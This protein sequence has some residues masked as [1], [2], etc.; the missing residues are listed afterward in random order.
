M[1]ESKKLTKKDLTNAAFRTGILSGTF[2]YE[3]MMG[4]GFAA[5]I[6]PELKKIYGEDEEGLR[7]ALVD[8]SALYNTQVHAGSFINGLILAL[9]EAKTDREVINGIRNGLF[10]PFAGIGDA[11]IWYTVVPLAAAVCGSLAKSG[12]V[13]G[14][15]LYLAIFTALY[16][17]RV[18]IVNM[19]YNLGIE[20]IDL[21]KEKTAAISE[22]ASILGL[23]V[24]GGLISSYISITLKPSIQ[25]SE[26]ASVS[27][28]G[29]LFDVIFPNILGAVFT[30]V[31]YRLLK[32]KNVKPTTLIIATV[33]IAI[34]CSYLGI[35]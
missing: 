8:H 19:G 27:L 9:E 28:Q 31:I 26:T 24:I 16:I 25:L 29:D 17:A 34:V 15:I 13:L 21:I 22:A 12:S 35:V 20:A 7:Q 5:S 10:G 2:N 18:P 11:I 33:V 32:N 6:A 23:T 4:A 14:P 3:N 1:T 30:F